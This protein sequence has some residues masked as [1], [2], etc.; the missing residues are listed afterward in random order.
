MSEHEPE[1]MRDKRLRDEEARMVQLEA[2]VQ[3]IKTQGESV[4]ALFQEER[5]SR[6]A[7][8]EALQRHEAD[9]SSKFASIDTRLMGTQTQLST[10]I[11]T[12]E[13]L[14]RTVTT[15]DA[16]HE[17]RIKALEDDLTGRSAIMRFMR[18]T[19]AQFGIGGAI[20]GTLVALYTV[21]AG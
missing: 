1:W 13:R 4:L 9:D 14:E 15:G 2:N 16:D 20:G 8:E 11:S 7:A 17:K 5:K 6:R 18:S 3:T 10:I 21:V 19:W 12:L